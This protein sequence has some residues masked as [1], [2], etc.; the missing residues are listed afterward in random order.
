MMSENHAASDVIE[1]SW[2]DTYETQLKVIWQQLI[3]LNCNIFL[4]E[5]I[6]SFPFHLF[7]PLPDDRLFWQ[8]TKNALIEKSILI[9]WRVVVDKKNSVL[10]I[11][12]FGKDVSSH[13]TDLSVKE[14]LDARLR[15]AV[16]LA[17]KVQFIR[18]NYIAHFN[19]KLNTNPDP[20]MVVGIP[21]SLEEI[22]QLFETARELFEFLCFNAYYA[23]WYWGYLN[24]ERQD[25]DIDKLLDSIARDSPLLNMPEEQPEIWEMTKQRYSARE[26]EILNEFRQKF[27]LPEV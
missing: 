23:L 1:A 7:A 16:E 18:H 21:L 17:N 2:L 20:Q 11:R 14:E 3:D 24:T 26:L 4:I 6:E 19:K 22:K 25:T 15:E 10:T 12:R 27:G 13:L 5:K 8:L 9:I